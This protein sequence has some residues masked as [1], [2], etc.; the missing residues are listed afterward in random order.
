MRIYF[1]VGGF[2]IADVITG[3]LQ[4]LYHGELNSTKLRQGLFHKLSEVLA[5]IFSVGIEYACEYIN[6]GVDLPVLSVVSVYISLMETI[7]IL[8]NLCKVNPQLSN[9]F[10]PYLEKLHGSEC[11][12]NTDSNDK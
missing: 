7:S 1:I 11:N 8:E 5:V 6:L 9:L 12:V 4:A 3:L 2:I 10:K